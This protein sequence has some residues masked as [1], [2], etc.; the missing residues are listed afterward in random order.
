MTIPEGVA[1]ALSTALEKREYT[2]LTPVQTAVLDEK[3]KGKDLL[4]SAQTGSG[5]TVA[6]GIAIAPELLGDEERMGRANEPLALCVAPTRE[7]AI[8]VSKEL[9]W[10]YGEAGARITTCVGGMD[11]RRERRNLS[12][13]AHIVVGTPGR[14]RD[15]IE[16]GSFDTSSLRTVVLDEADE[17]LDLGFREDLE[18]ILGA[19]PQER[20]TLLFSATVPQQIESLAKRF[21]RDAQRISTVSNREQHA[22]IEYRAMQVAPN[23][24]ENAIINVLRFYEAQNT[25]I[26]CGTREMVKH[27]SAR[28][29][30]RGFAVVAL[31]GELSQAERNH[32]LGAMRNGRARVCVATDVAARGIDLPNL[33]L[34]IHA[35]LPNNADTL[36]HRSGR[37]GRAG[38]KGVCTLVV[39][40]TRRRTATRLLGFAKVKAEWAPAPTADE[41]RNK[42]RERILAS[43]D[44]QEAPSEE[45]LPMVKELLE[46][47]T[48]EQIAAAYMRQI[49]QG[50]PAPEELLATSTNF[51]SER[52]RKPR[53]DFDNG[54]WFRLNVGRKHN[55]EPRW[56]LPMICRA[57]HITKKDIGSIRIFDADARFE[58]DAKLADKF[59]ETVKENG[60]GEKSITITRIEGNPER[61]SSGRPG[62][63]RNNRGGGGGGGYRGE[64]GRGGEGR[65]RGRREGGGGG[66]YRG[67]EGR[68]RGGEGRGR[69]EGKP[70][71]G[72]SFR[73][74]RGGE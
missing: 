41:I 61:S 54:V 64:G 36:L 53:K 6:F 17:M 72:K 19:A 69:G 3:L 62:G 45:D 49:H 43:S 23:D 29:G 10:L 47:F 73:D 42:D 38:R 4:V 65:G 21:Q 9:E 57:G 12:A 16:R 60:T 33:D 48:A 25:I 34:V 30:N 31:S 11:M 55:A 35:D 32:A 24:R 70:G 50:L 26:F 59:L 66:G 20:R 28:L 68:G 18:F 13:G 71:G 74:N 46:K 15:H 51:D 37:T 56:L 27:L 63:N 5:K 1:P 2:S 14:L 22:D 40:H 67:G 8:Q 7:L 44:L 39:P 52:E 58:L